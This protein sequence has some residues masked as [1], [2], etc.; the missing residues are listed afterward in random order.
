MENVRK[1]RDTKLVT[2]E[3]RRNYLVSE[4]NYHTTKYF[5]EN[6][7][8]TKMQ[9]LPIYTNKLLYLELSVRELS[10]RLMH[11]VLHDYV[12]VK[13]DRKT[14][15]CSKYTDSFIVNIKID[16]IDEDI[17]EDVETRFDTSDY[18]IDRSLQF[19]LTKVIELMKD[20]LAGKIMIEIIGLRS[21]RLL[22]QLTYSYLIYEGSKN[23]IAKST[24]CIIKRKRKF[25]NNKNFL[26][27]IQL[28]NKINNEEKK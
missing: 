8:A 14:K 5:T 10:K 20:Y 21:Y 12:K 16:D 28:E 19:Q 7:L 24:K 9:E 4:R 26:E 15:L 22:D 27:P 11:E 23:K 6:L 25:D 13:Y 1:N 17:S 3:R 18:E 2:A